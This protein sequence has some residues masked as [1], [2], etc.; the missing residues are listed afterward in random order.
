MNHR[1]LVGFISSLCIVFCGFLAIHRLNP[2]S[3]EPADAPAAEFASGRAMEHLKMIAR[4]PHPI[5]SAEHSAVRD[6][7]VGKLSEMQLSPEVQRTS[8]SRRRRDGSYSAADVQNILGRIEGTEQGSNVLLACHYDSVPTSF[9]ASDDG[10]GVAALLEVIRALRA[11]PPLRNGALFLFTDG[12]EAGLLGAQAFMD[13]HPRA[14]EVSIALN[15]E[16]RGTSGPS[17]MFETSEGHEWLIREFARAARH[18]IASSLTYDL[19]RLLPNDTDMTVFKNGGLQGLNFA[20]IMGHSY[21]HTAGDSYEN[22]DERSLQ[23]QGSLAL[24]LVRHFGNMS[25]WSAKTRDLIY[26][27]LLGSTV[28]SYSTKW[29][30]PLLALGLLSSGGLLM[31]GL[32]MKRLTIRGTIVG[33]LALL[34]GLLSTGVML[35]AYSMVRSAISNPAADNYRIE[36]S[37]IGLLLLAI[38][39]SATLFIRFSRRVTV[40]DLTMGALICWA[41]LTTLICLRVPGGSYLLIWPLLLTTLVMGVVFSLREELTSVKSL[42]LLTL[43]GLSEILLIAP[44]IWLMV[45]GLGL[46]AVWLL[47]AFTTFLLALH[48][49]HLSLLI[50]DKKFP[51]AFGLLGLCWLGAGSLMS[52]ASIHQPRPDHL[53]YALNA[54][55]RRAI[56]G[57]I[58]L[59]P[60]E[61]TAQFFSPGAERASLADLFPWRQGSFLRSDAPVLPLAPP[62]VSIIE[63][64]VTDTL[65]TL[66]L[67]ITSPR[68]APVLTVYWNR[69]VELTEISINGKRVVEENADS[70]RPF[71]RSQKLSYFG[72]PEGGIELSLKLKSPGRVVLGVEDRS[73][74]LPQIPQQPYR[75]RPDHLMALPFQDSDCTVV[76]KSVT[77]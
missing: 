8:I 33:A 34:A 20:Y 14:R 5:G 28:I 35:F 44:L 38:A 51:L 65:R 75:G 31:L 46:S 53:F 39:S 7:I 9:G 15:F 42:I 70:A 45:A 74:G 55:R 13:E 64:Q 37:T 61:W 49:A 11:S 10:A 12:E 43:P 19:Y 18:P 62:E 47:M 76:S 63:D 72:V 21:Y 41:V 29:V 68:Q 25:Q 57:S 36:I 4:K 73:Y 66:R 60:D 26:F 58:D 77:F 23:H 3:A 24:A 17:I 54:D 52:R 16:A 22:L 69:E 59:H 32:R 6:F 27:D 50:T 71:D 48:S 40:E 1:K 2:P 56:W 67:R 30:L